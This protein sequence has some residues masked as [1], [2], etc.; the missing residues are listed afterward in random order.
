[1]LRALIP[2]ALVVMVLFAISFAAA[3][4]A[5]EK[6]VILIGSSSS[7]D[8]EITFLFSPENG[9]AQEVKIAV[10]ARTNAMNIARDVRKEFTLALGDPYTVAI[11]GKKKKN[12]TITS[13]SLAGIFD[14]VLKGNTVA[15]LSIALQ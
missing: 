11:T 6:M 13:K 7:G 12:V 3:H 14:L 15:G 9:E 8:G 5:A 10:L 2:R 1:M 4:A